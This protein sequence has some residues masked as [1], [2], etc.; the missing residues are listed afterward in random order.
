MKYRRGMRRAATGARRNHAQCVVHRAVS[1]VAV[2]R[3]VCSVFSD[4]L[5]YP[6]SAW[7]T[8]VAD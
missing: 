1:V 3:L 7:Y 8:A 6:R 2:S 4:W 5:H